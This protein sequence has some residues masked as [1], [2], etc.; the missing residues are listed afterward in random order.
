MPEPIRLPPQPEACELCA[1][2]ALLTRHHL[3]PKSLHNKPYVQK[4]YAKSE[5]IT[6]TLWLCRACHNQVHRLFSEK[7]LALTYNT[8]DSLLSDERLR[9][10][11][12]WLA[13]KPAG[14]HPRH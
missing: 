7:E 4:R 8:R 1:R 2:N 3:I 6:A 13:D 5:R 9:T 12:A 14:F 10:F 11:V